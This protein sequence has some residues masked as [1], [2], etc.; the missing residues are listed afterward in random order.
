MRLGLEIGPRDW[1]RPDGLRKSIQRVQRAEELE[2]ETVWASED[3]DGWDAFAALATISQHTSRIFLGTGVTNPYLRH[4][5]LIAA[6]VGT[7]DQVSGGRAFL[8]LGRGE[9]DWYRTA[10]GMDIGSPLA[11]VNETVDVLRQWWS[12]DQVASNDGEFL[13]RHWRRAFAPDRQP[14][15]YLAATGPKMHALAGRVANGARFNLLASSDLIK[16]GIASAVASADSTGRDS[17]ALRFFVNPSLTLT[18][19]D[20]EMRKAIDDSKA[21]IATIH[22]LPGMDRQ[23]LGLENTFDLARILG[24]V[25]RVMHT[26]DVLA[27]GGS[28]ADLRAAGDLDAARAL[29]PDDLVLAVAAIGPLVDVLPRLR[30]LAECGVTDFL[31]DPNSVA[32]PALR[33]TIQDL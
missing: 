14:P 16:S 15:I 30:A 5:N 17:A 1:L 7:L 8:G 6:S 22:V 26:D 12:E 21:I 2:F 27:R 29:I 18:N 23:L 10:F 20:A 11:R 32:D 13:V 28:F 9:P 24:D 4:P 3:P 33:E 19:S 31:V 25:R